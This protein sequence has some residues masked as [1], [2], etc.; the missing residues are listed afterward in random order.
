MIGIKQTDL[1]SN[2]HILFYS[3][4]NRKYMK[5]VIYLFI[6]NAVNYISHNLSF[7]TSFNEIKK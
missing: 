2:K 1:K 7:S 6:C 3:E 4:P 5:A